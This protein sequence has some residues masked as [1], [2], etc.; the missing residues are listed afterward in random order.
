MI[1]FLL[2]TGSGGSNAARIASSKTFFN[3][4][5]KQSKVQMKQNVG[6]NQIPMGDNGKEKKTPH[7]AQWNF[8]KVHLNMN[9]FILKLC[10]NT[11][12]RHVSVC[13][14]CWDTVSK[15]FWYSTAKYICIPFQFGKQDTKFVTWN[16]GTC[17]QSSDSLYFCI[18]IVT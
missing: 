6:R 9:T 5:C 15:Q 7:A 1:H 14:D 3:P 11:V 18:S 16:N 13:S 12:T 8:L 17:N 4:F 10:I 2:F